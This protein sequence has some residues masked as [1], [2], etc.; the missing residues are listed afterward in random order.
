MFSLCETER[1]QERAL[2]LFILSDWFEYLFFLIS[3]QPV[4]QNE[5]G[6]GIFRTQIR[7]F[8]SFVMKSVE[9]KSNIYL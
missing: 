4:V 9:V 3:S 6:A 2:K 7:Q 5:G 8:L 1:R